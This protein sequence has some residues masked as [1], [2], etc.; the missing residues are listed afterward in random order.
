MESESPGIENSKAGSPESSP[1]QHGQASMPQAQTASP[2]DE[3]TGV[4][5]LQPDTQRPIESS[6]IITAESKKPAIMPRE[7]SRKQSSPDPHPFSLNASGGFPIQ[8]KSQAERSRIS[9]SNTPGSAASA[10]AFAPGI[11]S[12]P[13]EQS[14]K[15]NAGSGSLVAPEIRG[16]S[17]SAAEPLIIWRKTAGAGPAGGTVQKITSSP[18]RV[19]QRSEA[20]SSSGT[21]GLNSEMPAAAPPAAVGAPQGGGVDVRGITQQVLR[22]ITR[23]LEVERERRGLGK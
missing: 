7:N 18:A 21:L 8:R 22:D 16:N 15:G 14:A 2:A 5:H 10:A 13:E 19:V 1:S 20:S 23:R 6:Q 3:A 12:D 4:L 9:P 11:A 17:G